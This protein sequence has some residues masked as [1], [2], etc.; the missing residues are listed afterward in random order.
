MLLSDMYMS[1][2][3]LAFFS[4]KIGRSYLVS[5][6]FIQRQTWEKEVGLFGDLVH[7]AAWEGKPV[8]SNPTG[9]RTH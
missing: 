1:V 5:P 9:P 6:F 4:F 2:F 8:T 7:T 3:W